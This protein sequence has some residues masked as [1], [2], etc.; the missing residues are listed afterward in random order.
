M[1]ESAFCFVEVLTVKSFAALSAAVDLQSGIFQN[2]YFPPG[3]FDDGTDFRHAVCPD[4][5]ANGVGSKSS[6]PIDQ[7]PFGKETG[8]VFS[9]KLHF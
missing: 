2:Q 9:L 3:I 6:V 5:P 7:K 1:G 8:V 4:F